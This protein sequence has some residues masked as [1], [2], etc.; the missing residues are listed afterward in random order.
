MILPVELHPGDGRRP[1]PRGPALA[2]VISACVVAF[3]VQLVGGE[4]F[5][6]GYAHFPGTG[7]PLR[8]LTSMFLHG[9]PGHLLGN[10]IFL[11]VFGR[12]LERRHGVAGFLGLY[13]VSGLAAVWI[14]D[15]SLG[16]SPIG[17]E[18]STRELWDRGVRPMLGASGAISGVLAAALLEYG[19]HRV[20]M[21][22]WWP[23][24]VWGEYFAAPAW[25]VIALGFGGDIYNV[26]AGTQTGVA[27]W[28]HLGGALAG[29]LL[30][31]ALPG[32]AP[33]APRL[34]A[35]S[36]PGRADLSRAAAALAYARRLHLSGFDEE[37]L[38][39]LAWVQDEGIPGPLREA[40]EALLRT[41][42]MRRRGSVYGPPTRVG[43][44]RR[45]GYTRLV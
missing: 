21:I 26:L 19:N 25:V 43:S 45:G 12:E 8:W 37:A 31:L 4:P 22:W 3:L 6:L 1:A 14:H 38:Q 10:M 36:P 29:A 16:I 44:A 27:H 33:D 2:A 39:V 15:I 9:G 23:P 41:V 42:L 28:A 17:M 34:E 5:T 30:V 32:P 20:T 35:R 40:Y 18:Y 7:D 11:H 13:L 24:F